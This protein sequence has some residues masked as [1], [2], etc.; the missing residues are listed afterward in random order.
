[1]DLSVGVL[2]HPGLQGPRSRAPAHKEVSIKA[3]EHGIEGLE[4]QGGQGLQLRDPFSLL[5]EE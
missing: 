2:D 4:V 3:L 1:M 5:W